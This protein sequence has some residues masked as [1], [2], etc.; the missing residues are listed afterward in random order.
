MEVPQVMEKYHPVNVLLL[1]LRTVYGPIQSST[2]FWKELLRSFRF[3]KYTRNQADPCLYF[4]WVNVDLVIWIS[5][6][7]DCLLTGPK[8]KTQLMKGKIMSIFECE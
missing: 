7:D 1:L 3:K 4:I 2:Q 5:W 6:V 8:K